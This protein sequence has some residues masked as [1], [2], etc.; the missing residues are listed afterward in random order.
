MK[1]YI[2]LLPQLRMPLQ[3]NRNKK[4]INHNRLI[5]FLGVFKCIFSLCRGNT[6]SFH[7]FRNECMHQCNVVFIKPLFEICKRISLMDFKVH[8]FF[9]VVDSVCWHQNRQIINSVPRTSLI[10]I[11][12]KL[13]AIPVS[14]SLQTG[15]IVLSVR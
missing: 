8:K 13:P 1:L 6:F 14:C 11:R 7:V 5:I 4:T 15:R 3:I 2:Q 12:K 9:V 10:R